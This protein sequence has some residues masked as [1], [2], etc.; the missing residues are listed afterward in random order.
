MHDC[1]GLFQTISLLIIPPRGA[2][3]I[4]AVDMDSKVDIALLMELW[5]FVTPCNAHTHYLVF[6]ACIRYRP[7]YRLES[8]TV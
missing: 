3:L 8:Q 2:L 1:H 6:T 7:R 4:T 5:M